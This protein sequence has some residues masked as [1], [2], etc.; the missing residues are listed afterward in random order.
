[1]NKFDELISWLA[2]TTMTVCGL[3]FVLAVVALLS[4]PL[5]L[6]LILLYLGLTK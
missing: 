5:C 4:A 3:L 2:A 1:M 6:P